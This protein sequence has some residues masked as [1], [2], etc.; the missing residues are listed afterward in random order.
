[1]GTHTHGGLG[2]HTQDT[3]RRAGQSPG[4]DLSY[5]LATVL[6]SSDSFSPIGEHLL[7][8]SHEL[9]SGFPEL[10]CSRPTDVRD[11]VSL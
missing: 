9:S 7:P 1:M 3:E 10:V 11:G 5:L 6:L 2:G 8:G 4:R